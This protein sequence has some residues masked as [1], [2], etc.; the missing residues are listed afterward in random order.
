MPSIVI[1][2]PTSLTN[3]RDYAILKAFEWNAGIQEWVLKHAQNIT[4]NLAAPE[5]YFDNLTKADFE[6]AAIKAYDPKILTD[7]NRGL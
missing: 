1:Q 4:A 2:F 5:N 6:R 3:S 7:A